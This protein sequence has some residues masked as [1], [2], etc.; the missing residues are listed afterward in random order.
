MRKTT[1][2]WR[3]HRLNGESATASLLAWCDAQAGV[4]ALRAEPLRGDAGFRRYW[5]LRYPGGHSL[6]CAHAPPKTEDS[7]AFIALAGLLRRGGVSAPKIHA[8]DR[9]RGF[10][11]LE[12]FGD[13]P[14]LD[15]LGDD[16][17]EALYRQATETL[18]ALQACATSDG[19]WS[20][21]RYSR[22]MLAAEWSLFPRWFVGRL[23]G[24]ELN[25]AQR[26]L[27]RRT[28]SVLLDAALEQPVAL[29]HRD[30]HS[31]NLM[32][33]EDGR[34]GVLDFQDGVLG[35][36]SYD[37]VSLLKDCYVR[38]PPARVRGWAEDYRRRAQRLGLP[39]AE[40]PAQW[41][42]WFDLTG[43]QRH[44]KVL[45][46]FARLWLRDRKPR[47]LADLPRVVGYALECA[48]AYPELD[49]FHAWWRE[50]LLARVRRQ[51]WW[52]ESALRE[53]TGATP[54]ANASVGGALRRPATPR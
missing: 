26:D 40:D 7:D 2:K 11:L 15:A 18:S 21:P 46:I 54:P 25:R 52:D 33:A 29:V 1:G 30:Y 34:L 50:W 28:E 9:R 23:L 14:L 17:A 32:L 49:A 36:V 42:R 16:T 3:N 31:R 37:L 53:A 24:C 19:T 20:A 12:D 22:D 44:G 6:V 43:L 10:L 5:R 41:L 13:R 27:L 48:A 4:A 47:Y 45:G 39:S 35:P 8:A 51:P 38:W